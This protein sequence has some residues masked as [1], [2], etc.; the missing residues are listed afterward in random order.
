[1]TYLLSSTEQMLGKTVEQVVRYGGTLMIKFTDD[2]AC[3]LSVTQD[4]N[5]KG[6]EGVT[7]TKTNIDTFVKKMLGLEDLK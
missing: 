1:M 7:L 4:L 2:T 6:G 5:P 3:V